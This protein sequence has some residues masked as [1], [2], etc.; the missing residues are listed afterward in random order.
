MPNMTDLNM[1][2]IMFS[3]PEMDGVDMDGYPSLAYEQ[4]MEMELEFDADQSVVH[5]YPFA[6]QMDD[7]TGYIDI[8]VW[9]LLFYPECYRRFII[10]EGY[11]FTAADE[12]DFFHYA[13]RRFL[14]IDCKS[15]KCFD[16]M[17]MKLFPDWHFKQ[18]SSDDMRTALKHMYFA[19]HRCGAR[20]ILYKAGLECIADNLDEIP[21]YN[22][23]GT[24]P[25]KIIG[26]GLPLKLLRIMNSIGMV[27]KLK[28]EE[29]I[30][31]CREVYGRYGGYIG[32]EIPTLAQWHYL[33]VLYKNDGN[34]GGHGFIRALYEKLA[35]TNNEVCLNDYE[36]FLELRDEIRDFRKM[37]IPMTYDV[38]SVVARLKQYKK[39]KYENEA[40]DICIRDRK[41][42][43]TYEYV[44]A[45]Y[46]VIMPESSLDMG[47]EAIYQ[48]NCLMDYV[49]AHASGETTILFVRKS[50]DLKRPF[51][52]IEV[53]SGVIIQVRGRFNALPGRD[54]YEFLSDYARKHWLFIDPYKLIEESVT[55][56][57]SDLDDELLDY[58]KAYYKKYYPQKNPAEVGCTQ[59][60]V[61]D[62]FPELFVCA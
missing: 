55:Y 30:R 60:T 15:M 17:V 5:I 13:D 45:K 24:T 28:D 53:R 23:I 37:K 41:R 52:T 12:A 25:E 3:C 51:V 6:R 46:C 49:D 43:S 29:S 14:Y 39:C 42:S 48:R 16:E 59:L 47:K 61:E 19:S 58:A 32:K 11:R 2:R 10:R 35:D 8:Y 26:S 9:D 50:D 21:S 18:Y 57:I 40:A 7:G 38:Y 1:E 20:E 44:G 62:C 54:V 33:E 22:I 34:F 27:Y 4:F 56:D 31:F 36:M